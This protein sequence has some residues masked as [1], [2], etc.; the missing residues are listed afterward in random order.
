MANGVQTTGTR[1]DL[2]NANSG[3]QSLSVTAGDT[4][5]VSA[6]IQNASGAPASGDVTDNAGNSYTLDV[7]LANT[8]IYAAIWRA[9]AG[10]RRSA[11]RRTNS[12]PAAP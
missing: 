9:T 10:T 5:F 2:N 8:G 4:I 11:A 1:A 7:S 12:S 6:S 3:S